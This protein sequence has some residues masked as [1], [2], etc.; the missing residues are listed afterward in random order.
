MGVI[1]ASGICILFGVPGDAAVGQFSPASFCSQLF[2]F[3]SGGGGC[4]P[5]G[6]RPG[7]VPKLPGH[8]SHSTL[9]LLKSRNRPPTI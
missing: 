8:E 1:E 3:F 5:F 4:R 7:P 9:Q 6:G 2:P